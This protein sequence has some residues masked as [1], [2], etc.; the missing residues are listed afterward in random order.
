MPIAGSAALEG[1]RVL[2]VEDDFFI[3]EDVADAFRAQGAAVLGPVSGIDAALALVEA[4]PGPDAA[5]LD[6]NLGAVMSYPIADALIRLR[7]PFVFTTGYDV[8]AILPRYRSVPRCE[9]PVDLA[10][11]TRMVR[12][13]TRGQD[14]KDGKP[15][16]P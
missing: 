7:V 13:M 9:K 15:P 10:Q 8:S 16:L 4:V 11:V 3:A 12:G 5:V 6:L 2:I 1:C 14:G